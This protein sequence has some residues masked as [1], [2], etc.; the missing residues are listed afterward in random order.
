MDAP[1]RRSSRF[2]PSVLRCPSRLSRCYPAPPRARSGWQCPRPC[3]RPRSRISCS[4]R[5]RNEKA[6]PRA[7]FF[8]G[9]NRLPITS[10]RQ[11]RQERSRSS[12]SGGCGFLVFLRGRGGVFLR[13]GS[14][15]L[16]G[17]GGVFLRRGSIFLRRGRSRR[18]GI[19]RLGFGL[20]VLRKGDARR[21][22]RGD[23]GSNQLLHGVFLERSFGLVS[24]PPKTEPPQS[25]Q[26]QC[27]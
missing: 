9:V 25:L 24:S 11:G 1:T 2:S 8:T 23:Q 15:L 17:R 26:T 22:G 27:G 20:L 21:E 6:G 19:S 10:W 5:T 4:R 16:R 13:R 18:F 3:I 14:I 7:C 12:S